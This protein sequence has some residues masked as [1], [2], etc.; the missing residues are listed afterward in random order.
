MKHVIDFSEIELP[1]T[2]EH[3]F[4]GSFGKGPGKKLVMATTIQSLNKR[5]RSNFVVYA[6]RK[7]VGS[8]DELSLAVEH[9]NELP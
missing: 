8:Y 6:D 9:Y 7:M 4:A 1:F 2:H 3:M 5:P